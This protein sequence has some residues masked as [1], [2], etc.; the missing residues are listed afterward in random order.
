MASV[1]TVL[2]RSRLTSFGT[3]KAHGQAAAAP[4]TYRQGDVAPL[5]SFLICVI[6]SVPARR[7]EANPGSVRAGS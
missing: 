6:N 1:G 3:S 5:F 4:S 7:H 2:L